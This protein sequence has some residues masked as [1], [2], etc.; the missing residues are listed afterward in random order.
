[1]QRDFTFYGAAKEFVSF[2]GAEAVIHGP[3]ETGK[4]ISALWKLHLCA[5]KYPNASL[6]ISRKIL[7]IFSNISW[8]FI[9]LSF[10]LCSIMLKA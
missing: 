2:K 8:R 9:N 10:L 6:V 3:A 4:T 1:M 7:L 5:L